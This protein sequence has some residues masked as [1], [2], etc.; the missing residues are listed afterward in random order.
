MPSDVGVKRKLAWGFK[1]SSKSTGMPGEGHFNANR[2]R[3]A[4][5]YHPWQKT[6]KLPTGDCRFQSAIV[7]RKSEIWVYSV[8]SN[9]LPW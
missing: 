1:F 8:R 9:P 2:A 4:L 5:I 7:T 6:S 3:F